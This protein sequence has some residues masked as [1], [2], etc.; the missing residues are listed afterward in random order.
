MSHRP[1][2]RQLLFGAGLLA[3][4]ACVAIVVVLV[5][6]VESA[7]AP[8]REEYLARVASIC[9]IYGPRLDRI[10]PPDVSEPA[11]VIEALERVTPLLKAQERDVRALTPPRALRTRVDRWLD[12]QERRL[13]ILDRALRAARRQDFRTMSVA[14][15]DFVLAGSEAARL[16]TAIGIPQPPC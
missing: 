7:A 2:R 1:Y 6:T 15:V 4:A 5:F 3:T 13:A 14:Y 12:L 11:N 16:G 9:R 8:T 10:R